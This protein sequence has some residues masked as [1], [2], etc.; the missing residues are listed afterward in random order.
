MFETAKVPTAP[1]TIKWRSAAAVIAA[2][3]VWASFPTAS[4]SELG[5]EGKD[6][7]D[8]AQKVYD[9]A[10]GDDVTTFGQMVL[11][12]KGRDPR[13]RE[14][15][16]YVKEIAPG[17]VR[18]LIRF[19][20]PADVNGTSL[21]GA[22]HADGENDQWLY[23][24]DLGK[25]RRVPAARK[26]G[27]FVGSEIYYEDMQDRPVERDTHTIIGT[28][29]HQGK[30]CTLLQSVPVDKDNSTYSKR[31]SC[32]NLDTLLP[33]K[34]ELYQKGKLIKTIEALQIEKIQGFWTITRTVFTDM[35]SGHRTELIS[36]KTVYNRDLPDSLFSRQS[37]ED[38]KQEEAFRP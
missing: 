14:T 36:K 7:T 8:L 13:V 18:S 4:A 29:D 19:T 38:S 16:T 23:L 24:P 17:E 27:R 26:G 2:M 28:S 37:L 20:K 34:V 6:G 11:L 30:P 3:A 33:L 25:V 21:L 9:R 1:V 12:K 31:V 15:Y 22:D 5:T 35:K 32:V 10:D